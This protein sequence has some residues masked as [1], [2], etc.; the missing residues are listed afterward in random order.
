MHKE[1]P[2]WNPVCLLHCVC[3]VVLCCLSC[4]RAEYRL[5]VECHTIQEGGPGL[6]CHIFMH[7]MTEVFTGNSVSLCLHNLLPEL[8][9]L[10]S[11]EISLELK[12]LHAKR[13]CSFLCLI[14][15]LSCFFE[16][17]LSCKDCSLRRLS[18]S[19]FLSSLALSGVALPAPTA[20]WGALSLSPSLALLCRSSW[21]G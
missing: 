8:V 14:S 9:S 6:L 20:C 7:L 13:I 21:Q 17:C 16:C 4:I 18:P 3:G 15:S 10:I 2:N 1:L 19:A 11:E 5:E 12:N